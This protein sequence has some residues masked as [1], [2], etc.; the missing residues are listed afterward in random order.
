[1]YQKLRKTHL[2]LRMKPLFVISLVYGLIFLIEAF[3]FFLIMCRKIEAGTRIQKTG[4]SSPLVP[5]TLWR[6]G[7]KK[8]KCFQ[9]LN[10]FSWS[11][12][13]S[14]FVM[15]SDFWLSAI[16][17]VTLRELVS[18]PFYS[19]ASKTYMKPLS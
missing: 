12:L 10:C 13:E 18:G 19:T 17:S 15:A 1:M 7:R 14:T 5:A 16:T 8:T 6:A 4:I 3:F 9:L 2:L 11:G